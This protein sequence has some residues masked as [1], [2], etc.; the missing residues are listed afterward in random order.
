MYV[1]PKMLYEGMFSE[2][3]CLW[4]NQVAAGYPYLPGTAHSLHPASI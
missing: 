1:M 3:C 4:F 2:I